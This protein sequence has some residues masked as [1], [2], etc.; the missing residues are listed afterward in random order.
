MRDFL[1][2]LDHEL[3]TLAVDPAV[4]APEPHPSWW[5]RLLGAGAAF[6]ALIGT[7]IVVTGPSPASPPV[8]DGPVSAAQQLSQSWEVYRKANVDLA[9]AHV[10]GTPYGPGYGFESR[11]GKA[12]CVAVPAID[13]PGAWGGGCTPMDRARRDGVSGQ[14]VPAAGNRKVPRTF[15]W[16]V[17]PGDATDVRVEEEGKP[18]AAHVDHGVVVEEFSHDGRITFSVGDRVV[19]YDVRGPTVAVGD[20]PVDCGNGKIVMV[21]Q[22]KSYATDPD[23]GGLEASEIACGR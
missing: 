4:Y 22:P 8:L 13:D 9:K 20:I 14:A 15:A 12:L 11:D 2:T 16:Y 10:F 1:D 18:R 3:R 6:I 7:I 19:R 17:L 5:R 23:K 21:P